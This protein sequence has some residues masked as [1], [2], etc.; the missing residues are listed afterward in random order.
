MISVRIRSNSPVS[1]VTVKQLLEQAKSDD[2]SHRVLHRLATGKPC[3]GCQEDVLEIVKIFSAKEQVGNVDQLL[4]V[5]ERWTPDML[6]EFMSAK[7]ASK[8]SS[9]LLRHSI[10]RR[11]G[12]VQDEESIDLLIKHLQTGND[13]L[14]VRMELEKCESRIESK[15]WPLL[16]TKN[17]D[18]RRAVC[19]IL[20]EI[21]TEQSRSK[22]FPTTKMKEGGPRQPPNRPSRALPNAK[23]A[24]SCFCSTSAVC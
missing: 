18:V 3:E 16:R 17:D 7:L 9:T 10:I 19:H 21:G 24:S 11:L 5:L 12:K 15:L 14:Q 20:G 22:L 8:K 6:A 23:P 4:T 13:T 1:P 2:P